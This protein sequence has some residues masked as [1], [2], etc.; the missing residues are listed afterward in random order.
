MDAM[1]R[2]TIRLIA[3]ELPSSVILAMVADIERPIALGG[4]D[5]HRHLDYPR[6]LDSLS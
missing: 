2:A 3:P 5:L 1:R 4:E 6:H